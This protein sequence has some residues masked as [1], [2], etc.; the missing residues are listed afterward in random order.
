MNFAIEA[1][2]KQN[3]RT[4]SSPSQ[5]LRETHSF[6][7]YFIGSNMGIRPCTLD[8]VLR[9]ECYRVENDLGN[10][11]EYI[12]RDTWDIGMTRMLCWWTNVL[13]LDGHVVVKKEINNLQEGGLTHL[14][15]KY[16]LF[17]QNEGFFKTFLC[18]NHLWTWKVF[19][20]LKTGGLPIFIRKKSIICSLMSTLCYLT[21]RERSF[22]K[23][24]SIEIKKN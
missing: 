21:Q 8:D 24:E 19:I 10:S 15:L 9:D 17:S 16:N 18:L 3:P 22:V 5:C 6:I 13:H 20:T 1:K 14:H 4:C 12:I 7:K 2:S 11:F 23:R